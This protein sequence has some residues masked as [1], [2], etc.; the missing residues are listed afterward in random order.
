MPSPSLPPEPL[1]S[2][3]P[4]RRA[5][6]VPPDPDTVAGKRSFLLFSDIH[7]G[8]DLVDHVRPWKR[9]EGRTDPGVDR[10]LAA[11]LDHYREVVADDERW[12]AIIAGDLVDFIGMNLSIADHEGVETILNAEEHQ[13][14]L[15]SARDH[16]AA[17]VRATAERHP[18]VFAALGRFVTAGHSL[19]VVRGNHDLDFHWAD[20]QDAFIAAMAERSG[21]DREELDSR[22]EFHAW[23]YYVEGLLFVEHGHQYDAMC[24]YPNL[25]APVRPD[26]P[27]RLEW[28][29]SDW[30]LRTVARPT[31]GLGADGHQSKGMGEYWTFA[32]SV[33]L[34]GMLRLGWRFVRAI[35][36]G[37]RTGRKRLGEAAERI[38]TQHDKA[39]EKLADRFV[40]PLGTLRKMAAL[41]PA[42]VTRHT[43]AVLRSVFMDRVVGVALAALLVGVLALF[44]APLW[45]LG[46]T[47]AAASVAL[48]FYFRGAGKIREREV[49]PDQMM[50]LGAKKVA[51]IMPS[52]FIVMG[53]THHPCFEAIG[54]GATYV[55]L[56]HWGVDDLDGVADD[57]PR[58]HLVLRAAGQDFTGELRRWVSG[59]GPEPFEQE[60]PE[61]EA[62]AP[63]LAVPSAA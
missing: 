10:D 12:T 31:P 62:A 18:A 52:R 35:G 45:V 42:P 28:S 4:S 48:F 2:P 1:S 56:G 5:S 36:K 58:T 26:D 14:G 25:L 9:A 20:A 11:M 59:L 29:F 21:T 19:V 39:M 54:D 37:I 32:R 38:K 16:A 30:L 47:A 40:T 8:A 7:L 50:K 13:H 41:W 6:V 51:K 34:V 60:H 33:G 44:G 61:P 57:P 53:H 46:A 22:V 17:K 15:G 24:N 49:N 55:N 27:D 43:L 63:G 23:F 3:P